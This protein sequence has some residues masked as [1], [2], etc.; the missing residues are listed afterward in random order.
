MTLRSATQRHREHWGIRGQRQSVLSTAV[1]SSV[2]CLAFVLKKYDRA[3]VS[4]SFLLAMLGL[5]NLSVGQHTIPFRDVTDESGIG[6]RHFDGSAGRYY[7][8]ETMSGGVALF[9]YD[10]D[11]DTDIYFLNGAPHPGTEIEST[12][13]NALYRN[14]GNFRFTD[15]TS[16]AGVGDTN[17]GLG[18]TVGDY[19]NDGDQDL[20]LNNHGPNVLYRNNGDGTFTDVTD[21]SGVKNGN[22]VGAGA[23]FLDA[24]GDGDLDLYAANYVKFRY[25]N[26]VPRTKQ[27]YPIYGTPADYDG[28]SDTLFRNDGDGTFTDVSQSSGIGKH[29]SAGMG[30]VCADYDA[31]G[32]TD[33]FVANDGQ[34]NFLF[35]NDGRGHFQDVGLIRGFAYDANGRTHASMGVDCGDYDNDGFLDFHVT[36]FQ[37]EWATLYRNMAGSLLDDVTTRTRA[38]LGTRSV[39]TWGNCFADFDNDG[40]RDIFIAC[41]HLYDRLEHFDQT[42]TYLSP[43]LILENRQGDGFVNISKSAGTGLSVALSSRAAGAEDLDGDGDLDVVVV[44][45]R[46]GPTILRNDSPVQNHWIAVRLRGTRTNRDGVG[47]QVRVVTGSRSQIDEVHAGRGYQGHHGTTLHFGLGSAKSVERIEVRWIG[48]GKDVLKRVSVDQVV[49][50]EEGP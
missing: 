18:V 47:A 32:D 11:G 2:S 10:S 25:D 19:D 29:A 45:T 36:S 23:C 39:V 35:Q 46:S 13:Q 40:D 16:V 17:H 43:N 44:N 49:T 41:G 12:P 34:A 14:D 33:I 6:F 37:N 42:S 28:E 9:D 8:V 3:R 30:M 48:G 38:G 20:Y 22:R 4:A 15:A 5:S 31:D 7:L 1:F 26:H 50:I 21:A 24:D 27:G